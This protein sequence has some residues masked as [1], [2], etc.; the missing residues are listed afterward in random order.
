MN[1]YSKYISPQLGIFSLGVSYALY[2]FMQYLFTPI[3]WLCAQYSP[4]LSWM[5]GIF[6]F[7]EM[8]NVEIFTQHSI[9]YSVIGMAAFTTGYIL[10]PEK[11]AKINS[12]ILQR[13]W[14][15]ISAE[16]TFW[17][18]FLCGFALKFVR[19]Q[20]GADIS[21]V[22]NYTLFSNHYIA[23]FLSLNWL[24]F[25]ALAVINVAYQE[26]KAIGYTKINRLR[27]I[28]YLTNIFVL[29]VSL[30]TGGRWSTIFPLSILLIIRQFYSPLSIRKVLFYVVLSVTAVLVGKALL[31]TYLQ[32]VDTVSDEG[33]SARFAL[34]Y[35]LL[36]RVNMSFVLNAVIEQGT[37]AFPEGTLGQFWVDMIPYGFAR[38]N[39]FDGNDFGRALGLIAPNDFVTG[40]AVTNMG[41]FYINFGL[42]GI[43]VG[44]LAHGFL[45]KVFFSSC[46][47]R[48]P[49]FVIMYALMW[50]ILMHGMESPITVLYSNSIKMILLCVI[51]HFVISFKTSPRSLKSRLSST[52]YW[53]WVGLSQ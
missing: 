8:K 32:G 24:H 17:A 42:T 53:P 36:H 51:I 49:L 48:R 7:Y 16:W 46:R 10:L 3:M 50:P 31:M 40:V 37:G 12:P 15:L 30:T 22:E 33:Y 26:G 47:N 9:T 13:T 21:W 28:V 44:M 14:K 45:Y 23:F 1:S 11:V 25:I 18:L 4:V 2:S 19:L 6:V 39:F 34:F 38:T 35:I 27:V 43:M 41:D 52:K 29:A 5:K 20:M